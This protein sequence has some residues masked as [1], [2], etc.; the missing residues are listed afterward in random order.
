MEVGRPKLGGLTSLIPAE[1]GEKRLVA[2]AK[3]LSLQQRMK[4]LPHSL[5]ARSPHEAALPVLPR[6][7]NPR[8]TTSTSHALRPADVKGLPVVHM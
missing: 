8:K 6:H 5:A 3:P 1:S 2:R 7:A 4:A